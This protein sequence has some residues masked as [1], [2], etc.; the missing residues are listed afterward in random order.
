MSNANRKPNNWSQKKTKNKT[1]VQRT[2][3]HLVK[4]PREW[5]LRPKI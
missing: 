4:E 3:Y 2:G 5:A 1:M